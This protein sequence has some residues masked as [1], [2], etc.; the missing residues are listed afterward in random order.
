MLVITSHEWCHVCSPTLAPMNSSSRPCSLSI[1]LTSLVAC[2]K[3][4]T[5]SRWGTL[6]LPSASNIYLKPIEIPGKEKKT[7]CMNF[8]PRGVVDSWFHI[9]NPVFNRV[10]QEPTNV[11]PKDGTIQKQA[12]TNIHYQ[13]DRVMR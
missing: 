8:I 5:H 3:S 12:L 6:W 9:R 4:N 11:L 10:Y 2:L 13:H 1:A 7:V